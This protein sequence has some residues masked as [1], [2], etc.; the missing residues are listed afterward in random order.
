MTLLA[1]RFALDPTP[2]QVRALRSNAGAAR[3]AFNWALALVKANLS[4]RD[5]ERSYGVAE[6]DLTP[7]VEWSY[8]GLRKAWNAAKDDVAPWWRECSKEAFNTGLAA[9]A[10]ALAN[11]S[12]SRTGK[13]RGKPMGFPRFRSKRKAVPAIRWTT[14]AF[15]LR[16]GRAVLPR[17][18]KVAL[19]EDVADRMAGAKI[20]GVTVRLDG[21]RWFASF[22][23]E[24]DVERP[25]ALDPAAVVGVDLGIKTLAVL[26]TGETIANPRHLAKAER[27]I[28]RLS[29]TVSRR[30][31]ADRRTSSTGS[32]RWKRTAKALGRAQ[33]RVAD[34][35]RDALHKTTTDLVRRFGTIVVEDLHVAGMIRNRRLAK[36]VAD[37]SFG[38]FRRQLEYKAAWSGG[39][40]IVADRWFASSKTCSDCGA[41]RAKL[42]L[43]ERTFVCEACGTVRDRDLNAALNLAEYGR[44]VVAASGAE[45]VNGRGAD[46]QTASGLQVA[47]KRQPGTASAGQTGT[48]P[49][50]GGTAVAMLTHAS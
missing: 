26:S 48:V 14:G 16:D 12:K 20:L 44:R 47:V 9:C 21:G 35:R 7:S 39:T 40:V 31:G 17:V 11:W 45:T 41:V 15:G 30:D 38:E 36:H 5:A 24:Q 49:P 37:A 29:R 3:V 25:A 50:Q 33:R 27:K 10:T 23:V 22:T 4:Q 8:Y 32:N 42:A 2:A 46:R 6:T 18:G 19:F 34:L 43:S 28:R 13:R 1:H